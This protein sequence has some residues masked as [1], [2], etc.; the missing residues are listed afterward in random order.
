CDRARPAPEA[1]AA[2]HLTDSEKCFD[3]VPQTDRIPTKLVARLRVRRDAW[4][5]QGLK[6]M[7]PNML[8]TL[9]DQIKR[10]QT[11]FVDD[12]N[13][14]AE[15]VA[16]NLEAERIERLAE[17]FS[18]KGRSE[19]LATIACTTKFL[20]GWWYSGWANPIDEIPS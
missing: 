12:P 19:L 14:P 4:V 15:V 8:K 17:D 11:T 3:D 20:L 6:V 9:K 18:G 1:P 2:R 13:L 7:N 16:A 10:V 5:A